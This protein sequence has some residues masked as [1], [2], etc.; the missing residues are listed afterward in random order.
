MR[1]FVGCAGTLPAPPLRL[2]SIVLPPTST[3]L[4]ETMSRL[5]IDGLS[6]NFE[7]AGSGPAV[8]LLHGWGGCIASMGPI[9][10]ALCAEHS[11]ISVDLPGF[12]ESEMPGDVWGSAEFGKLVSKLLVEAG[13]P[14][15]ECAIGHSF[16]G[17]VAIHLAL[18]GRVRVR[19]LLLVGTPGT[20]L[21]LSEETKRSIARVKRAKKFARV[22]P[23]PVRRSIEARY[24]K[25]G[26]EDYRNAGS[27]RPILVRTVNEDLRP[28]LS[29]IRVPTLLVFG[30]NDTATPVQIGR[31]MESEIAGSGLVIMEKSGHFP[32]LDEPALF[33]A[34]ATSFLESIGTADAT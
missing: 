18:T 20:R 7:V 4:P 29:G 10:N 16:G 9:R 26:S 11:V 2:Q 5:P 15:V 33:S 12:G 6:V 19:S 31:I 3:F 27:M 22:L 13:F 24:E 25:L 32:Y 1:R 17:K 34:V 8:V 14:T 28:L 30:A 21:P 23:G